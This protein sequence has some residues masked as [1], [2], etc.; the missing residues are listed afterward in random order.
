MN[1]KQISNIT[2]Q[3]ESSEAKSLMMLKPKGKLTKEVIS[4]VANFIDENTSNGGDHELGLLIDTTEFDGWEYDAFL[5]DVKQGI[6]HRNDVNKI[7]IYGRQKWLQ[8][9]ATIASFATTADVEHFDN[10]INAMN[11]LRS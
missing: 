3:F 1:K 10:Q 8:V 9:A 4:Q 5:E 11:W 6:K 2:I 7:A